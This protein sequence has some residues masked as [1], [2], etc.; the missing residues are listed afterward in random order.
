MS[1][2][3]EQAIKAATLGTSCARV[4]HRAVEL[5]TLSETCLRWDHRKERNANYREHGRAN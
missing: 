3:F 4:A 1:M 5:G 2:T